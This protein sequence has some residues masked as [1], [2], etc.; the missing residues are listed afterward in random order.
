MMA[1]VRRVL[2]C[3]MQHLN[4]GIRQVATHS[5]IVPDR[6]GVIP[7][8]SFDKLNSSTRLNGYV[9]RQLDLPICFR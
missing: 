7:S 8:P 2:S 3:N 1:R 9:T 5:R 6:C 4:N